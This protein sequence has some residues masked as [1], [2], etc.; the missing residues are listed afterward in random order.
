MPPVPELSFP[1]QALLSDKRRQFNVDLAAVHR[2]L[3]R[4]AIAA[5]RISAT[6]QFT[7]P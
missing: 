6:P 4:Q 1:Q 2:S 3:W 5:A 7:S